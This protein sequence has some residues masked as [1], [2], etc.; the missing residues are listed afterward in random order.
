LRN[1]TDAAEL[2]RQFA[3]GYERLAWPRFR[4]DRLAV[5]SSV[6]TVLVVLVCFVGEPIAQRVLGHGPNDIFPMAV[7]VDLVPARMWTRVPDTDHV[8]SETAKTPRTLFV[9][10]ADGPVGH[11]VFLRVLDGGRTSLEVALGAT[12]VAMILGVLVG[13]LA[14]YFR[15]WTDAV[16]MR[17]PRTT[18][19]RAEDRRPGR[20]T[21]R[22]RG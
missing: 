18:R 14:G 4:S 13:L 22:F 15:G 2:D 20:T 9:L 6:V 5:V 21:W 3:E 17:I 11:D 1:S 12:A 16:T 19:S 7:G 8:V 10:G